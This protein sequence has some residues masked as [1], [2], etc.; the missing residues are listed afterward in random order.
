MT[1]DGELLALDGD[2]FMTAFRWREPDAAPRCV[3]SGYELLSAVYGDDR[4]RL[5]GDLFTWHGWAG[6]GVVE[7]RIRAGRHI[8]QSAALAF[9][10]AGSGRLVG[11]LE[12][13]A[14]WRAERAVVDNGFLRRTAHGQT[15]GSPGGVPSH[16]DS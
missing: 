10:D 6:G 2:G 12:L 3:A 11:L 8:L 4:Y 5:S 1:A 13:P 9:L 15:R 16:A 14:H 7:D